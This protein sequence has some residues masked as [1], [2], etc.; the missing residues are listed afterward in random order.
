MADL[1][2]LSDS[3]R[4]RVNKLYALARRGVGGEAKTAQRFLDDLLKKNGLSLDDISNPTDVR[5]EAFIKVR[6]N[7]EKTI[8]LHIFARATGWVED[9]L[10]VRDLRKYDGTVGI[11]VTP[12]ESALIQLEFDVLKRH[13]KH[14]KKQF[15]QAW[16]EAQE[17]LAP[18]G[19]GSDKPKEPTREQI[20]D[21]QR[22][23]QM[24][25]GIRK[26]HVQKRIA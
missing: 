20:E 12:A 26:A 25:R 16:I 15:D 23:S 6:T 3:V 22:R 11:E 24:A 21:A 18:Y 9:R 13:H 2:D 19:F 4:E 5:T 10:L 7:F 1:G 8:L 14:E 17:L